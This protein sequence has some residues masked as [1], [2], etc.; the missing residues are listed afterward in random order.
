M[1]VRVLRVLV[2]VLMLV[3]L[4][5]RLKTQDLPAA[6]YLR[7]ISRRRR[8]WFG[9]LAVVCAGLAGVVGVAG[10]VAVV[11]VAVD[12]G[13]QFPACSLALPARRKHLAS[14][15]SDSLLLLACER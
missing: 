3:L 6:P 7:V 14:R 1:L 4:L 12:I 13:G 5:L 10:S 8:Q 9:L 15:C 11:A 2:Q